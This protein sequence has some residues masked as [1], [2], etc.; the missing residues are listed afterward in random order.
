VV[1]FKQAKADWNE[2]YDGHRRIGPREA[3]GVV[4]QPEEGS[5]GLRYDFGFLPA[6]Y[7]NLHVSEKPNTR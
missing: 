4:S 5:S 1:S 2:R 3:S 7:L 6:G